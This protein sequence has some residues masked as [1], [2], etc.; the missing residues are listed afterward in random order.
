MTSFMISQFVERGL[1]ERWLMD[2]CPFCK[3]I[4][5]TLSAH[6]LYENEDV[7]AIL[8]MVYLLYYFSSQ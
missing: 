4:N 5:R 2:D 3:I 7:I 8:G 6:I 1:P